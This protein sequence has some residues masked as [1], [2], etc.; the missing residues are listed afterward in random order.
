MLLSLMRP[1][2]LAGLFALCM[3]LWHVME[4]PTYGLPPMAA[5]IL[6]PGLPR[7]EAQAIAHDCMQA[8]PTDHDALFYCVYWR[9]DSWRIRHQYQQHTTNEKKL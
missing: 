9:S 8:N 6:D 4:T 3:V 5:R 2:L 1:L 7:A